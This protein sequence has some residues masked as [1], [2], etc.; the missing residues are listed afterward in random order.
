VIVDGLHFYI[1]GGVVYVDCAV[2]SKS[3][4]LSLLSAHIA[5]LHANVKVAECRA[6]TC[7]K[8]FPAAA[9]Q[10]RGFLLREG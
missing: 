3:T 5:D 1:R 10:V 8:A 2:C 7:K 4:S 9:I 6:K